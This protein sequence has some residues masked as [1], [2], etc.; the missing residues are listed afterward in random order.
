MSGD[1][2]MAND[3]TV[4]MADNAVDGTDISLASEADRDM[5]YFDGTDWVRLAKGTSG[6]ILTMTGANAIGW[7]SAAGL[8][9]GD[10]TTAKIEALNSAQ[11]IIGTNGSTAGNTKVVLSGDVTMA[12]NGAVTIA[13]GAVDAT[14]IEGLTSTQFIIG[15]DGTA[16]NNAK[17]AMSGDA[18]MA[19]DGTVTIAADAVTLAKMADITR[20]SLIIGGVANAPSAPDA[21]TRGRILVGGGTDIASVAVSGDV[22][23]AST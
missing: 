17:V 3:G 5:M 22:T 10:V 16:A 20:G 7:G 18:T 8:S 1:A 2:T 9:D 11:I 4:T 23:M 12:N 13:N 21:K 15:V 6:Q 14:M 19:N